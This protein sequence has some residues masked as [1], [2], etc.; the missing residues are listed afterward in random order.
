MVATTPLLGEH[1]VME[2]DH[3]SHLQSYGEVLKMNVVFLVSS[4][5]V[6]MRLA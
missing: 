5:I 6:V 2:G 4:V 3:I 1:S